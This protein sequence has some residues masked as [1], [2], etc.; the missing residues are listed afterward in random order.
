M[1]ASL[2][3]AIGLHAMRVAQ[4]YDDEDYSPEWYEP[5][6]L[7]CVALMVVVV[8]LMWIDSWL[9]ASKQGS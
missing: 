8:A 7:Y 6:R 1:I 2:V 4:V 9:L 3:N 5:R